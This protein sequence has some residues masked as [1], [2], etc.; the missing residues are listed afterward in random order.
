MSS[1]FQL[2]APCPL[3]GTPFLALE[4]AMVAAGFLFC[5]VCDP[6]SWVIVASLW[7]CITG[8]AGEMHQV[9]DMN[10]SMNEGS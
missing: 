2:E 9:K 6:L 7:Y 10:I 3:R 1:L 4:L 8:W 5:G